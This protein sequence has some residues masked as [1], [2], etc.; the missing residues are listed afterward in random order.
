MSYY[1]KYSRSKGIKGQ[2]SVSKTIKNVEHTYYE[3]TLSPTTGTGPSVFISHPA[4]GTSDY[5]DIQQ[6]AN[7][8]SQR[9]SEQI[10]IDSLYF[11]MSLTQSSIAQKNLCRLIIFQWL[12]P[13]FVG[14]APIEGDILYA[15]SGISTY[16][17]LSPLNPETKKNYHIL[18]DQYITLN[19]VCT[20]YVIT[21]LFTKKNF[22]RKTIRYTTNTSSGFSAETYG[23]NIYWMLKSD[24]NV[25]TPS[26]EMSVVFSYTETQ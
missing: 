9:L 7:Q 19:P 18:Y 2:R 17:Y 13:D 23:G 4:V 14:S 16:S 22:L 25:E 1:N 3:F 11:V 21:K 5:T 20:P 24:A 10:T 26:M 12:P 15:P 8:S 6:L